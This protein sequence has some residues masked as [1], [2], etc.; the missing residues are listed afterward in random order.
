MLCLSGLEIQHFQDLLDEANSKNYSDSDIGDD[1]RENIKEAQKLSD[2]A[3][4]I[5][6]MNRK[7]VVMSIS[8]RGAS[9]VDKRIELDELV[10]FLEKVKDMP[11]RIPEADILLVL[12]LQLHFFLLVLPCSFKWLVCQNISLVG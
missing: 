11:C 9:T 12:L 4:Q 1:L 7:S 3:I 10:E 2:A 6:S 5:T 8:T